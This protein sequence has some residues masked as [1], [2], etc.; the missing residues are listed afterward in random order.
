MLTKPPILSICLAHWPFL[1]VSLPPTG[2]R[3]GHQV[4][5]ACS[6]WRNFPLR[7]FNEIPHVYNNWLFME[8]KIVCS[9]NVLQFSWDWGGSSILAA[10]I[11]DSLTTLFTINLNSIYPG[12][13]IITRKLCSTSWSKTWSCVCRRCCDWARK[14]R[15]GFAQDCKT[16]ACLKDRLPDATGVYI[17]VINRA[18]SSKETL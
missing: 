17:C 15:T 14:N 7:F 13:S 3:P 6:I 18:K 16:H 12:K 2:E 10:W 5:G 9:G 8:L 4:L 11:V 1:K